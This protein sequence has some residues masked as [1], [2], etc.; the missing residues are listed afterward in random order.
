MNKANKIRHWAV[1]I[2]I[3]GAV[4]LITA[5]DTGTRSKLPTQPEARNF[6]NPETTIVVAAFDCVNG[7]T[8]GLT[9]IFTNNSTGEIDRYFWNF[10]DSSTSRVKNPVH[11]YET[12]GEYVVTL[13]VS[14]SISSDTLAQFCTVAGVPEVTP[15]E[16]P[17]GDG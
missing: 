5:C 14:N 16:P 1:L 13:T 10:G 8:N 4:G 6:K 11:V 12:L 9:L 15:A 2:V 17:G 7:G 3:V